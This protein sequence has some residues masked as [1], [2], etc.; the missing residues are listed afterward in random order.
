[1]NNM[2]EMYVM[3]DREISKYQVLIY[4]FVVDISFFNF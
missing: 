2:N 3:I 4:D 1:M